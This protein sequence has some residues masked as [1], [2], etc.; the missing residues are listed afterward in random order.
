MQII[1]CDWLKVQIAVFRNRAE[2]IRILA[3]TEDFIE[4]NTN[5]MA[6]YSSAKTGLPMFFIYLHKPGK[7]DP[8]MSG[9]IVHEV[10]HLVDILLNKK[11]IETASVNTEVRGHMNEWLFNEVSWL[12]RSGSERKRRKMKETGGLCKNRGKK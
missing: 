6:G 12:V 2:C 5:G 9:L 11:G 1:Y 4:P 3:E 10:S 8:T 7:S